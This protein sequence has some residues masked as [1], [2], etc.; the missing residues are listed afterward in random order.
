MVH[1]FNA[2]SCLKLGVKLVC[3]SWLSGD[4]TTAAHGS[5]HRKDGKTYSS[6]FSCLQSVLFNLVPDDKTKKRRQHRPAKKGAP[7]AEAQDVESDLP[8]SE[9]KD[10]ATGT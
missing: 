6:L 10:T 1:L 4:K 8:E 2:I 3:F 5:T 7:K 9:N